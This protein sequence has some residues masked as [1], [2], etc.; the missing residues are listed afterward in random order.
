MLGLQGWR[1]AP[2]ADIAILE[3]A[4]DFSDDVARERAEMQIE[5]DHHDQIGQGFGVVDDAVEHGVPKLPAHAWTGT[6]NAAQ[7][8][9]EAAQVAQSDPMRSLPLEEP[10][11]PFH[12][13][14]KGY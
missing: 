14:K 2:A 9:G 11:N 10:P 5:R 1:P 4:I 13:P 6:G 12:P 3:L 8:Q 7:Q